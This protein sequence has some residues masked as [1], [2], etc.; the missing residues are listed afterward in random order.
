MNPIHEAWKATPAGA[1]NAVA[2]RARAGDGQTRVAL[3][4]R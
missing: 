1:A 4:L 2:A 3:G